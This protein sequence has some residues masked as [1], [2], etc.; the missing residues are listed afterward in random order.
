MCGGV[1]EELFE[2]FLGVIFRISL[3][4]CDGIKRREHGGIDRPCI[5]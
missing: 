1:I 3:L 4:R 5:V 2:F